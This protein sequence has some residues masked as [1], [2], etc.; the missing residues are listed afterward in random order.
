MKENIDF[1]DNINLLKILPFYNILIDFMEQ[2]KVKRLTNAELLNE[3]PF[4]NSLNI[5]EMS[6]AFRRYPRSF[7]IEIADRKYPLIQ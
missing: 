7:S 4:Y 2:P 1:L 5:K 6:E 3:L